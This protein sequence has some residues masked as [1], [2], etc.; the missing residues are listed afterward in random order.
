MCHHLYECNLYAEVKNEFK[1]IDYIVNDYNVLNISITDY[2]SH[3][4]FFF[5]SRRRHTRCSRD[6]SS[7]VCSSDLLE[8]A[9]HR[10]F[11]FG[12]SV[13]RVTPGTQLAALAGALKETLPH[14]PADKPLAVVCSG[15]TRSEEHTSE[16]QSRLHLVCRLLL[17]KKKQNKH[18]SPVIEPVPSNLFHLSIYHAL[19]RT[20]S[21]PTSGSLTPCQL[22]FRALLST[23]IRARST[24]T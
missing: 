12:K 20:P 18:Q 19:P 7:D 22:P 13:L 4:F 14:L 6:W 2:L 1:F 17:E 16:L 11:R 5:S 21:V 15:Q 3:F 23:Q 9:A 24:V 10:V 8:A